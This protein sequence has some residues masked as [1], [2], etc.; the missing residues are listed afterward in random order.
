MDAG[1]AALRQRRSE[2]GGA[3]S[4]RSGMRGLGFHGNK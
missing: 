1:R 4:A 3:C 2:V